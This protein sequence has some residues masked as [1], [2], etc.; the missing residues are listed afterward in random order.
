MVTVNNSTL[1]GVLT[2]ESVKYNLLDEEERK[3]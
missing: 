2:M 1:N 3:K